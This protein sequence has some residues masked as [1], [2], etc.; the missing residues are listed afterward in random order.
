MARIK[1]IKEYTGINNLMIT[2]IRWQESVRRNKL[3]VFNTCYKNGTKR[4][5]NIIIDWKESEIWEYINSN[6]LSYPSLYNEGFERIG[7]IMCPMAKHSARIKEYKRYPKFAMLYTKAFDNM[8]QH[9]NN[10]GL[11]SHWT[12]GKELFDWWIANNN[13]SEEEDSCQLT[14]FE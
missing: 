7:C 5:L 14:L 1:Y 11:R 8:L 3:Q 9:R 13:K 6:Q 2:G 10:K 12:T 4:Y